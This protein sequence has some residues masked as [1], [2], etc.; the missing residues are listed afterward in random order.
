MKRFVLLVVA[1]T[2]VVVF[3]GT[4]FS[5]PKD[6]LQANAVIV[7][8]RHGFPS[9]DCAAA[10][11]RAVDMIGGAVKIADCENSKDWKIVQS[12]VKDDP[13][14]LFKKLEQRV[15][16][17]P[18]LKDETGSRPVDGMPAESYGPFYTAAQSMDKPGTA[19]VVQ[20]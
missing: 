19:K 4:A 5:R 3:T 20:K 10:V 18:V 2:L 8:Y 12:Y 11:A 1:S 16:I 7:A 9:E 15:L 17:V 14:E 6:K 13:A